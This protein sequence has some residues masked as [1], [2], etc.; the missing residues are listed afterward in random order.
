MAR[1]VNSTAEGSISFILQTFLKSGKV[2]EN[3]FA[4]GD[5]VQNL[6][7][8]KDR[9]V[10]VITGRIDAIQFKNYTVS[11]NYNSASTA[12]SYFSSDVV[13]Y[14]LQV[15]CSKE[16]QSDIQ[17]VPI[18]EMIEFDG[19]TN[20]D[21]M[22]GY[23][24]FHGHFTT[25]LTDGSHYE[26]DI[27]EGDCVIGLEYLSKM[28][29]AIIEAGRVVAMKYDLNLNPTALVIVE[30]NSIRTIDVLAIKRCASVVTPVADSENLND[31]IATATGR[32]IFLADGKFDQDVTINK[33][34]RLFGRRSGIEAKS[35]MYDKK[36]TRYD[37]SQ[38]VD[39]TILSG[40]ITVNENANVVLD[41]IVL[42][43]KALISLNKAQSLELHNCIISDVEPEATATNSFLV[44]TKNGDPSVRIVVKKCFFGANT[45]V[46][47]KLI[48]NALELTA[49]LASGSDVSYNYFEKGVCKNNIICF[50]AAAEE[51]KISATNNYFEY[52]GNGIR[53]ATIGD[54]ACEY[55]IADNEYASTE[56]LQP[57]YAGLLL[58]QPYSKLT[59]NFHKNVIHMDRTVH[60]DKHQ[61]WYL[62]FGPDDTQI[63]EDMYPYLY[64][65]GELIMSPEPIGQ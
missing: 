40:K 43:K 4:E 5:V 38:L 8:I 6:R 48:K 21:H 42:T 32:D 18:N 29:D 16:Y 27:N 46:G 37:I 47:G 53:I 28:G 1:I 41:G 24:K 9:S 30:G 60:Y 44:Y 51:A 50:Y 63:A 17:N 59:T 45:N 25:D 15:D 54:V 65:D 36:G 10:N 33:N 31:V 56:E 19:V 39:E 57:D 62:Y 23:L 11:R 3:V 22:G 12:K 26:F 49:P 34:I 20:V 7:F 2:L 14:A 55:T 35:R 52:S 61:T 64:I 58:I 13:P